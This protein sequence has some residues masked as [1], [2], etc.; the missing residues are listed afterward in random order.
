MHYP[1]YSGLR[2]CARGEQ[3]FALSALPAGFHPQHIPQDEFAQRWKPLTRRF[4]DSTCW[5]SWDWID[6]IPAPYEGS[7]A[8]YCSPHHVWTNEHRSTQRTSDDRLLQVES[9][10][11]GTDCAYCSCVYQITPRPRLGYWWGRKDSNLQVAL[12]LDHV[13]AA[14]SPE[15]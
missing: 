10:P 13:T 1:I 9:F 2:S 3:A 8:S 11:Y 4:Y 6:C 15:S 7:N 14:S 12:W 5:R